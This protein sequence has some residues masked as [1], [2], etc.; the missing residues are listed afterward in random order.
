MR[1]KL[2]IQELKKSTD[3]NVL[4][5]VNDV[6]GM[7]RLSLEQRQYYL[8]N[9]QETKAVS[10]L[11]KDFIP[12]IVRVAYVNSWKSNVLSVLDLINEGIIGAYVGFEKSRR[13]NKDA[14][15][16]TRAYIQ[17]YISK[18]ISNNGGQI[19]SSINPDLC[20]SADSDF[21]RT[22]DYAKKRA[23]LSNL[24]TAKMGERNGQ[25]IIDYFSDKDTDIR[26][27]AKKYGVSCERI[28]QVARNFSQLYKKV[29]NLWE[30]FSSDFDLPV[31]EA[32][33]Y[34]DFPRRK[35]NHIFINNLNH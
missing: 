18:M 4:A 15:R 12:Y 13:G 26:A 14:I 5:F 9:L 34:R 7:R 17:N 35:N 25:I 24:L 1:Y 21:I 19:S 10:L 6:E 32:R 8:A 28:H 27:L 33:F 2:I 22:L 23:L 3:Q 29:D 31:N 11:V 16:L 20:F 30:L